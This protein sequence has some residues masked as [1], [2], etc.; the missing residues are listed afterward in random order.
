MSELRIQADQQNKREADDNLRLQSDA[1]DLRSTLR[2][3]ALRRQEQLPENN[4]AE[5]FTRD[6]A[7]FAR[8]EVERRVSERFAH[9][10]DIDRVRLAY[11]RVVAPILDSAAT[12]EAGRRQ[13][14][15]AHVT[16][17]RITDLSS[18]LALNATSDRF[19]QLLGEWDE[20]VNSSV[21]GSDAVRQRFSQMGRQR[22]QKA[23]LDARAAADP[24]DFVRRVIEAQQGQAASPAGPDATDP[25]MDPGRRQSRTSVPSSNPLVREIVV[26]ADA[27]GVPREIMLGIGHIE[28]RLNTNAG[29]PRRSDGTEMSSAEGGWQIIDQMA[30]AMGVTNK[31]DPVESTAAV[32]RFLSGVRA[33]LQDR[34]IEPTPGLTYMHWNMGEGLAGAVLRANPDERIEHVVHRVYAGDPEFAD[35]VLANNPSLYRRGMTVQQVRDRY[36][37]AMRDAMSATSGQLPVETPSTIGAP[38]ASTAEARRLISSIIGLDASELGAADLAAVLVQAQQAIAQT[39]R[40]TAQLRGG[41][42]HIQGATQARPLQRDRPCCRGSCRPGTRHGDEHCGRRPEQAS[43]GSAHLAFG[44]FHPGTDHARVQGGDKQRRHS[45]QRWEDCDVPLT[46]QHFP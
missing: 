26:Q 20:F 17:R 12:F 24:E 29:R 33:R 32:A 38:G 35:K 4:Q 22:L 45:G 10:S 15:R 23:L 5:N 28:S 18:S 2:D 21:G 39:S 8:D 9:R 31:R 19:N 27:H 34:G 3:E 14:W 6:L 36:D 11:D 7:T 37:A 44:R 1:L 25:A 46:G 30:R 16:E 43:G 13:Q 40:R 41:E 42:A